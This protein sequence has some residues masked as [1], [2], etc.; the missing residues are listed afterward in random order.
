MEIALP[1]RQGLEINDPDKRYRLQSLDGDFPGLQL[2]GM[3]HVGVRQ[4]DPKAE[5]GT[6]LDKE[7]DL[8]KAVTGKGV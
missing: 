8:A 1:G 6:G 5:T 4:F 3:M 7:Y 2:L